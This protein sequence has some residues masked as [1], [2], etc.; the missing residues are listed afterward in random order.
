[1]KV[2]PEETDKGKIIEFLNKSEGM[3]EK[4]L[5]DGFDDLANTK[6]IQEQNGNGS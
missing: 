4:V 1:M 3:F 5:N 2:L 6:C